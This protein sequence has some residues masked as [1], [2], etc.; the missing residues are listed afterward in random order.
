MKNL[1]LFLAIILSCNQALGQ[2]KNPKMQP[3]DGTQF[4]LNYEE[5]KVTYKLVGKMEKNGNTIYMLQWLATMV[6]Q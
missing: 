6:S 1:L 5:I 3:I 2:Q 4:S